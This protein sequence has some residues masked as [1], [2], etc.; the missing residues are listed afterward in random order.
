MTMHTRFLSLLLPQVHK[1]ALRK[2]ELGVSLFMLVSYVS[3][4]VEAN[5]VF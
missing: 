4:I 3:I 2:G 5:V 1:A